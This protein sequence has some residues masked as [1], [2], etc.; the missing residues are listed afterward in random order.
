M[1]TEETIL[2]EIKKRIKSINDGDTAVNIIVDC[3]W[4]NALKWV[5]E[6]E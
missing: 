6:E 4:V 3:D 5:L 2:K 1:K